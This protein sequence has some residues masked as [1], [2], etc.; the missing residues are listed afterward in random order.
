MMKISV[1]SEMTWEKRHRSS[2]LWEN[3]KGTASFSHAGSV[4]SKALM[5]ALPT[6]ALDRGSDRDPSPLSI[7]VHAPLVT[8]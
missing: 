6:C 8:S 4:P 2:S 1:P 7:L 3:R 5:A